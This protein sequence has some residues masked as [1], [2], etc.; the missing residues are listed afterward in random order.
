MLLNPWKSFSCVLNTIELVNESPYANPWL[1]RP[2]SYFYMKLKE[3][4]VLASISKQP[5]SII[6]L[7]LLLLNIEVMMQVH[8][9]SS[10]SCLAVLY[11]SSC[12]RRVREELSKPKSICSRQHQVKE[13]LPWKIFTIIIIESCTLNGVDSRKNIKKNLKKFE[14]SKILD[15]IQ[16]EILHWIILPFWAEH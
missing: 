3:E 13:G 9:H 2:P 5:L 15:R 4:N 12:L 11:S 1:K 7:G 8:L 14:S 10:S 16:H 6:P